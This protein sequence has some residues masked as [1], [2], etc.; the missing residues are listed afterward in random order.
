MLTILDPLNS[1]NYSVVTDVIAKDG[2]YYTLDTTSF[3]IQV[4]DHYVAYTLDYFAYVDPNT[5][6]VYTTDGED[7]VSSTPVI[8]AAAVNQAKPLV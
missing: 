7:T 3:P 8:A 6:A 4:G 1:T 2:N 5:G